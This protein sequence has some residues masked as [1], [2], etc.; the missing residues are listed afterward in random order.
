M[1]LKFFSRVFEV[2]QVLTAKARITWRQHFN[3]CQKCVLGVPSGLAALC[4]EGRK[5]AL[6]LMCSKNATEENP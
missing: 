1:K 5:K 4:S 3:E 6:E 2:E